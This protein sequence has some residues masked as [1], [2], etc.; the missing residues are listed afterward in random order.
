MSDRITIYHTISS[1]LNALH[2]EDLQHLVSTASPVHHGSGSKAKSCILKIKNTPVFVKKIPLTDI[3]QLSENIMSSANIFNLPL[4][5][6]YGVGSAGFGAWRE[7]L[8]HQLTT[9]WVLE[10]KCFGFPLL[11]HRCIVPSSVSTTMNPD[12]Q[13]TLNRDVIY[14]ENSSNIRKR[15]EALH[16]AASDILLF[17]E[18]IPQTLHQWLK[19]QLKIGGKTAENAV[20]FVNQILYQILQFMHI[21]HLVHFDAHFKNILTDGE[22]LYFTDFGLTLSS[23]FHLCESETKFFKQHQN[24]DQCC[25]RVNFLHTI[26]TSLFE[27]K[28]WIITLHEFIDGQHGQLEPVITALIHQYAP[29]AFIMDNFFQKLQ[30][31]S[32]STLF[33]AAELD[34][35][36]SAGIQI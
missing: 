21:N 14:W 11:Y 2:D 10:K 16:Y 5:Y 29:I 18:Y 4:H 34:R 24:Y 35:L 13:E 25:I 30:S 20:Q 15:L 23:E 3:E 31:E 19:T 22:A 28:N 36:L 1:V 7:L 32:K 6:Q 8:V 33:P 9:K 17:L 26:I 27:T 12:Q